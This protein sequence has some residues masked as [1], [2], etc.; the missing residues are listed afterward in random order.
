MSKKKELR[1]KNKQQFESIKLKDAQA[2]HFAYCG[3]FDCT[4]ITP[5]PR[6]NNLRELVRPIGLQDELLENEKKHFAE[7]KIKE[8]I[9]LWYDDYLINHLNDMN[10]YQATDY[11]LNK[12]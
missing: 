1:E 11:I 5:E 12:I 9:K 7:M 2:R 8:F 3:R 4:A 10:R 6:W